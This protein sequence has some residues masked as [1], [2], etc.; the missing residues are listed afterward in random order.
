[1]RSN[2]SAPRAMAAPE[3]DLGVLAIG[4]GTKA[5]IA[6]E[7]ACR[8]LPRLAGVLQRAAPRGL[9]PLGL[10]WQPCAVCTCEG[11]GLEPAHVAR[12]GARVACGDRGMDG[13]RLLEP[14]RPARGRPPL[15]PLIAA[16]LGEAQPGSVGDRLA[17]DVKG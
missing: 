2:S 17:G 14:P 7:F 8:P 5:P 6:V 16:R 11:V 13:D 3:E 12:G 10:A 15:A 9:L 1:M 4:V